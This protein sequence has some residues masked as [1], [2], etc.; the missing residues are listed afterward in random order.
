MQP[1]L[2]PP[3]CHP[4]KAVPGRRVLW[5]TERVRMG[6]ISDWFKNLFLL[7]TYDP[8]ASTSPG[9]K[10]VGPP[11]EIVML[12]V[13]PNSVWKRYWNGT[14]W[15]GDATAHAPETTSNPS[16]GSPA[17]TSL[18]NA[19]PT[20]VATTAGYERAPSQALVRSLKE[21]RSPGSA[22]VLSSVAPGLGHMYLEELGTGVLLLLASQISFYVGY[23]KTSAC[24]YD[25]GTGNQMCFPDPL[26][27]LQW[28]ARVVLLGLWGFA[29]YDLW[30]SVRAARAQITT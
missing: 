26:D 3:F 7:P 8:P 19:G 5:A 13:D 16:M 12:G 1:I 9:W 25:T 20:P 30:R 23:I 17:E 18:P 29:L 27:L 4:W 2:T 6:S 15:I 10:T 22:F 21:G 11:S 28:P 14:A 24:Y